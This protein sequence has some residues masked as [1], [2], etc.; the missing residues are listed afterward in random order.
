MKM[1]DGG[2]RPAFNVQ[3]ATATKGQLIAAVAIGNVGSDQGRLAPMT[4]QLAAPYGKAP[5]EM[6]VDGG[7]AKLADI[8]AV[9]ASGETTVYAPVPK[10]RDPQRD[11]HAPLASDTPKVAA[12]RGRMATP[13][14]KTICKDRAATAECVNAL[15]RNRGLQRSL[16]R[17]MAK[18]KAVAL[19][20]ALAHNL[21][22]ITSLRAAT[23]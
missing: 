2:F 20:F 22:R 12:W 17:G 23:A 19:W 11:R 3:F 13:Q 14:P 10:P 16:V 7:F 15:A 1:A 5:G 8:E 21:A 4:E 18:A 6:L 9:S